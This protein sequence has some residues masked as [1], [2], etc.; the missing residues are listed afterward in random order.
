MN[1]NLKEVNISNKN[2][3]L[4]NG[5]INKCS[6]K[7]AYNF[8]YPETNLVVQNDGIQITFTFIDSKSTSPVEYNHTKYNVSKVIITS[9]SLH[10]FNN[11]KADAE[12]IVEHN[13]VNGGENLW[14]CVPIK[15]SES[16]T[17]FLSSIIN[18]TAKNRPAQSNEPFTYN[19]DFTLQQIIPVRPYF[20][21]YGSYGN[22]NGNFI[23]FDIIDA[24]SIS[25]DAY[26]KIT[27]AKSII[28]PN[29]IPMII[30]PQKNELNP[31]YYNSAG[32]NLSNLGSGIYIKCKPTGKSHD[33]VGITDSKA[34]T[35]FGAGNNQNI[36]IFMKI[37]IG[38][39][40][41]I[42]IFSCISAL[43]TYFGPKNKAATP[44]SNVADL[45]RGT[46]V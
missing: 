16:P 17:Q 22:R 20:N 43:L 3:V 33:L 12:L 37:I 11:A 31:L 8:N 2:I 30:S 26:A 10:K 19:I 9:P 42:F 1:I 18:E 35:S 41:M 28:T 34:N 27:G 24:I 44:A 39:F 36:M 32:P 45:F 29:N 46:K 4:P 13:P 25:S 5:K 15:V 6:E 7:C 38:I 14:V 40:L 23:V 21:Y